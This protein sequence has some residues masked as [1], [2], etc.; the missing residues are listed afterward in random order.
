MQLNIW[1]PK[2]DVT[3]IMQQGYI[4]RK[5]FMDSSWVM[6]HCHSTFGL[7][8]LLSSSNCGMT[9]GYHKIMEMI[10]ITIQHK[11]SCPLASNVV[12]HFQSQK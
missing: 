7:N 3:H 5:L 11:I 8:H 10:P 4:P 9:L 2:L 12:D 1:G 6:S